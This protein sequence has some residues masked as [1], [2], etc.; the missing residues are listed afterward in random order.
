[1]ARW[2]FVCLIL[3]VFLLT[4]IQS[5]VFI[6]HRLPFKRNK[7]PTH[8]NLIQDIPFKVY[9]EN[10]VQKEKQP[11]NLSRTGSA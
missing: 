1:M 3:F 11:P 9:N 4:N 8:G 10:D 2:I 5:L 7:V 6:D